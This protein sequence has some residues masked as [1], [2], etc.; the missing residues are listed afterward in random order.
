MYRH[1]NLIWFI[2]EESP[3]HKQIFLKL[4]FHGTLDTSYEKVCTTTQDY[5]TWSLPPIKALKFLL[6]ILRHTHLSASRQ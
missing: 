4:N 2:T 3:L 5:R 6:N 1:V